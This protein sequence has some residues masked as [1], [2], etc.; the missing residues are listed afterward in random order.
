MDLKQ[1]KYFYTCINKTA[2]KINHVQTLIA[3]DAISR[4]FWRDIY[5][6][7]ITISH[8][9]TYLQCTCKS[10]TLFYFVLGL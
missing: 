1:I 2:Y 3:S 6:Y 4:H 5:A 7:V 10:I 9:I 8:L